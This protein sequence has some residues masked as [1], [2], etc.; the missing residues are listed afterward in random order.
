MK[1]HQRTLPTVLGT[2]ALLVLTFTP[3][4]A[5]AGGTHYL[6]QIHGG[7][8]TSPSDDADLSLGW[9]VAAGYGGRL[10]G[11]R[12]RFYGLLSFDR[13]AFSGSGLHEASGTEWAVE[14]S[15][16]D[17]QIGI[18]MLVPIWWRLR[19]YLALYGG[20]SYQNGELSRMGDDLY[21]ADA[22]SLLLTSTAGLEVRWHPNLATGV[23]FDLRWMINGGEPLGITYGQSTSDEWR[24]TFVATQSFLF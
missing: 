11:S 8:A 18:R 4:A 20:A 24:M 21:E 17:I 23:R 12:L 1:G 2:A 7:F 19:F 15:Y 22:W 10:R 14:R 5:D 6:I 13:A 16:N 3:R 9:G